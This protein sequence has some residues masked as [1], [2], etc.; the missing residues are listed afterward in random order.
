[1]SNNILNK[2]AMRSI[3][4]IEAQMPHILS[5]LTRISTEQTGMRTSISG[6]ATKQ[7]QIE[8]Q[9]VSI[10]RTIEEIP[11]R[12]PHREAI[13]RSESAIKDLE[14]LNDRVNSTQNDVAGLKTADRI[15]SGVNALIAGAISATMN[16]INGNP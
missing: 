13:A 1:M 8:G 12:C 11:D 2:G 10:E 7:A 3:G 6:M 14:K 4:E 5:H 15:Y 9:L 16:A